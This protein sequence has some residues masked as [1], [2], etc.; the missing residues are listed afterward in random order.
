[1]SASF[2]SHVALVVVRQQESPDDRVVLVVEVHPPGPVDLMPLL[3]WL[4]VYRGCDVHWR[5]LLPRVNGQVHAAGLP[6]HSVAYR[7][8]EEA[9]VPYRSRPYPTLVQ[10]MMTL[11]LPSSAARIR[12][13]CASVAGTLCCAVWSHGETPPKDLVPESFASSRGWLDRV[14]GRVRGGLLTPERQLLLLPVHVES[15]H[16]PHHTE[17]QQNRDADEAAQPRVVRVPSH[18]G[19]ASQ[20]DHEQAL[21]DGVVVPHPHLPDDDMKNDREKEEVQP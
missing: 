18:G 6:V 17:P 13:H 19:H 16:H 7:A 8:L 5:K 21:D 4:D 9:L 15:E 11:S 3:T 14:I 20:G 2:Y 10:A 1:M 12:P